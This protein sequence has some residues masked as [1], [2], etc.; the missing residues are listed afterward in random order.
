VRYRP[1]GRDPNPADNTIQMHLLQLLLTERPA[2]AAQLCAALKREVAGMRGWVYY[3]MAPLVPMLRV[4]ELARAGC[5]LDLPES[6]RQTSVDGQEIWLTVARLLT[7]FSEDG[8]RPRRGEVIDVLERLAADEFAFIRTNPP[9]LYHN[10]LTA[11][12]PRYY[13][14]EDVGYA[15][16]LR[17][18]AASAAAPR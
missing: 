4:P 13:W 5:A 10:D 17:L 16:W 12:V 3:Q 8:T 1:S 7:Q 18:A 11:T 14:S 6:R 15:L 2:A 9:L